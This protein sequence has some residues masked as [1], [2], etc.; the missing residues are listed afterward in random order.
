MTRPVRGGDVERHRLLAHDL[1]LGLDLERVVRADLA[2]EP[3]LERR[4]DAAAIG[5]VLGVGRRQQH[6]V[7]RQTDL[8]AADLDVAL[9]EHVEHADLDPL[10]EVGQLVDGEDAPVRPR[11]QAV[12]QRQFVGQVATLGDLDRVDLADQVGDRRVGRGEL[13][14]EPLAAVHPV[15]R[16]VVAHL[17]D[18]IASV[19][20]HRLVGVVV[21]LAAGDDRH[22]LV[23]QPGERTDHAGLG[24]T[25]LAEED[26]VVTGEQRV[27]ELR[28]HGVLVAR[29]PGEERL[30]GGDLLDRVLA[31]LLLHGTRH[32][33]RSPKLPQ[34]RRLRSIRV[35]HASNLPRV[36]RR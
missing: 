7:E 23:E 4:D 21:D 28:H 35:S 24:L 33:A 22:P 19:L 11:D 8:V 17:R 2:A 18:Q 12:V 6:H 5:V 27:L 16:R 3:I 31:N 36:E 29:H 20:R 13:L 30:A 26:H 10:G 14:A 25:T 34:R 15:D 9:L 32:P 1:D